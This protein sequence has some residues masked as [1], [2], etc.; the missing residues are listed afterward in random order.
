MRIVISSDSNTQN[1]RYQVTFF[2]MVTKKIKTVSFGLKEECTYID[3]RDD[4]KKSAYLARHSKNNEDWSDYMS[5]D[6]LSRW[7]LWSKPTITDSLKDYK[8]RFKLT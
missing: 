2:L 3:H 7:L 5:A 4:K 1:K 8:K 6:S